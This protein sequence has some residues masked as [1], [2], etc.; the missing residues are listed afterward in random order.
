MNKKLSIFLFNCDWND[1]FSNSFIEFKDK[2]KRDRLA[3]EVNSFFIFSWAKI[4][5]KKK[6]GNCE[7]VHKRTRIG[8][9]RPLLD[10]ISFLKIYFVAKKNNIKPDIW[11]AYDFGFL[12]ALWLA[13][14][15]FGGKIV[16]I[17]NNQPRIYSRTRSFGWIKG[18]YSWFVE[19]VFNK[20]PDHFFTINETMNSYI[21]NLGIPKDRITVFS[22]NTIERDLEYINSAKKGFIKNKLRIPDNNKVLITVARLEP[23]KN[24]PK[25]LELFSKLGD[26]YSLISLGKGSLL[27]SLKKQAKDLGIEKRVF[28]EGFIQRNEIWNYYIDSDIFVLLSK[29]EALGVVF[30]EAM[31]M[32]I[33]VIGSTADGIVETIGNDKDRG[34]IW[35]ENGGNGGL[36]SFKECIDFCISGNTERYDML[37]CAKEYVDLKIKNNITIN[38]IRF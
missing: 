20:I 29:A 27:E 11:I 14:R 37:R 24:Y 18:L 17:L 12:P 35:N 36:D 13:K 5:Y 6:D 26:G 33:P 10:L 9:I 1:M 21:Q 3:P 30:W 4:S 28:F 38:E 23:E 34:R 15:K 19:K 2:L 32:N 31:Y 22:M 7:T 25:L 16:M 8:K